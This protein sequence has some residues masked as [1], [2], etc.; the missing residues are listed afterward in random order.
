LFDLGAKKG[1]GVSFVLAV[2]C[3]AI[4]M[5]FAKKWPPFEAKGEGYRASSVSGHFCAR[6][7]IELVDPGRGLSYSSLWPWIFAIVLSMGFWAMFGWLLWR[8]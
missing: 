4:A 6:Q 5:K 1:G 2:E 7:P 8:L 3:A